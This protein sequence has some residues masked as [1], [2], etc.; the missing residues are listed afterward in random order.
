[1]QG[2][3]GCHCHG[4]LGTCEEV[5]QMCKPIKDDRSQVSPYCKGIAN[6]ERD[7]ARTLEWAL[8]DWNWNWNYSCKL[9]VFQ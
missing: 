2:R 5:D 1:M 7:D 4:Q 8:S 9:L 6:I 3:E